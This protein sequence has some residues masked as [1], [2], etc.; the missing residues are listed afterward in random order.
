MSQFRKC[1]VSTIGA[2]RLPGSGGGK[3][4][5]NPA[6]P[7]VV[8]FRADVMK[9]VTARLPKDVHLSGFLAAYVLYDSEDAIEREVHAQKILGDRR[10]SVEQRVGEEFV[11]R[12][13]YPTA[14][15]FRSTKQRTV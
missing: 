4:A 11:K 9:A 5:P 3:A 2:A 1:I 12:A 7:S 8:D 14:G 10:H 6:R 13:I 15:Y